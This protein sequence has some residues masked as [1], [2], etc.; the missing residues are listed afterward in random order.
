MLKKVNNPQAL[1]AVG[2]TTPQTAIYK[3]ESHKLHQAF[4]V[5]K[6]GGVVEEIVPGQPVQLNSDGTISAYAGS[7]IY[8]GIAVT[9]SQ[10]PCYPD[11]ALGPEV[12][13]MMEGFAIIYGEVKPGVSLTNCVYINPVAKAAGK[14]YASYEATASGGTTESHFINLT[15]GADEMEL[16]QILVR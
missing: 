2:S 3:S 5:K 6:S 9:D 11:G 13:V 1:R 10:N 4:A 8:L 16:I 7:G 12:T 15:P 14:L